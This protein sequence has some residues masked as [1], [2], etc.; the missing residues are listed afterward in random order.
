MAAGETCGTNN[1]DPRVFFMRVFMVNG[2]KRGAA[3]ASIVSNTLLVLLKAV[4]GFF[5]GSVSIL[6]EAVHSG[7]DLI[8][9]LIAF[10]AVK[11]ADNPPDEDHPYGHGKY[12][13]VSGSIEAVLIVLAAVYIVYEAVMK[14]LHDAPIETFSL[15][16]GVVVM[17]ISVVANI[18]VSQRLFRVAKKTDSIALEAD[19]HHLRLDV[20]TS[21]GILVG[22]LLVLATGYTIIDRLLGLAVGLWIGWIGIELSKR[23][24]SPLLDVQLPA[25]ELE[26]IVQIIHSEEK[27]VGF[28]KLRTRK[29]GAHRHVDVHLFMPNEMSLSEAHN[30][31][32]QVEDKIRAELDNVFVLT[33]IEPEDDILC[34]V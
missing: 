1:I 5:A 23:A 11:V 25:T 31:A 13:N 14:I 7:V 18:I 24:V 21:A 17:F 12:E 26:R 3:A 22:L 6:A 10:F 28:H 2:E 4:V 8:A 34:E 15:G 30:L 20:Y 16:I 27:V 19:G 33:H 9:A 32:E 29:S